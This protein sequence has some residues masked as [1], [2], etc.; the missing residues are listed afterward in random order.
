MADW[1]ICPRGHR[2]QPTVE[3]TACPTCTAEPA[4]EAATLVHPPPAPAAKT[5]PFVPESPGSAAETPPQVPGYEVLG[6]LGRGG[7]GVVYKARHLG[8]DRVVALKMLL[9]V[10]HASPE[11]INR[12]RLEARSVARLQHPHIVQ[13]YEVGEQQGTAFLSLEYCAGG[14]LEQKLAGTPLPP[15][16]AARLVA[17]LA[18]AVQAAHDA[19]IV[20]RDLKPANVLLTTE[21]IAKITDFGLAKTMVDQGQTQSGMILGTPSYMSP[22]QASGSKRRV[23]GPPTDIYALG[24]I[25]YE[26]LTGRPPFRGPTSLDTLMQVSADEPARPSQLQPLT[27]RDLEIICLKCLQKDAKRRYSQARDLADDLHRYLRGEPIHARPTPAWE[28]S[29]KWARRNPAAALIV[30]LFAVPLPVLLLY[31]AGLWREAADARDEARNRAAREAELRNHAEE[32]R[33]R[34]EELA[35]CEGKARDEIAEDHK[36]T[37]AMLYAARVSLAQQEWFA[38]NVGRT[39]QLLDEC[40]PGLRGWEWRHLRSLCSEQRLLID[41]SGTILTQ[42]AWGG[43]GRFL[44]ARGGD[45]RLHIWDATTGSPG[46]VLPAQVSAFAF[47]PDGGRLVTAEGKEVHVWAPAT[48]KE[49]LRFR[50]KGSFLSALAFVEE[51]QTLGVAG[52][53]GNVEFFDAL[54][55]RPTRKFPLRIGEHSAV[56]F[57]PDGR[58]IAVAADDEVRVLDVATGSVKR[59][60]KG[61]LL[62]I[63]QVAFS[64][65]GHRVAASG[66]DGYVRVWDVEDGRELQRL[67]GHAAAIRTLAWSPDGRLLLTGAAD[68][69]ARLWNA[70]S[71][72]MLLTFRGHHGEVLGVAFS[73]EGKQAATASRDG[74]LRVWDVEGRRVIGTLVRV[75][76]LANRDLQSHIDVVRQ[77]ATT[78]WGHLGANRS[79]AFHPDGKRLA[80]AADGDGLVKVW[81]LTNRLEL[82]TVSVPRMS[83]HQLLFAPVGETLAVVSTQ[84]ADNQPAQLTLEDLREQ[85]TKTL[86]GPPCSRTAGAFR[87]DGKRFA[88]LVGGNEDSRIQVL[89]VEKGAGVVAESSITGGRLSGL[90]YTPDGRFL[91]VVGLDGIMR[92]LNAETC[93][94]EKVLFMS[95]AGVVTCTANGLLALGGAGIIR[96]WDLK[97][98]RE[99]GQ[100]SGHIGVVRSLA[101]NPAG[102]RLASCGSDLTA[103]VWHVPDRRELLTF[104]SH[105]GP[106]HCVAWSPDGRRLA[107]A[108][109]DG[110]TLLFEAPEVPQTQGWRTLFRDDFRRDALGDS[111][112]PQTGRWT[113][114]DGE[115][116]GTLENW[117]ANRSPASADLKLD[118][119]PTVAVSF[120][121]QSS[122]DL[123]VV[124]LDAAQQNALKAHLRAGTG[125]L[126]S[127][128]LWRDS[129]KE[130]SALLD[131]DTQF[132][133][134]PGNR[135]RLQVV[136]QPQRLTLIVDDREVLTTKVPPL[137]TPRLR[138]QAVNA[139]AGSVLHLTNFQVTAPPEAIREQALTR[140]VKRV[141]A[142]PMPRGL[143]A[144]FVRSLRNLSEEDM[145]TA[146]RLA[147]ELPEDGPR[148]HAAA[149]PVLLRRDFVPGPLKLQFRQAQAAYELDP[150][151]PTVAE[152]QA[153]ALYRSEKADKALAVLDRAALQSQ[154]AIGLVPPVQVAVRALCQHAL[155]QPEAARASLLQLRDLMLNRR[156]AANPEAASLLAEA[157][158]AVGPTLPPPTATER[159]AQAVKEVVLR[160]EQAGWVEHDRARWLDLF[161]ED[162]EVST[163][164]SEKPGPEDVTLDRRRLDGTT[165]F[166]FAGPPAPGSGF[167]YH[168]PQVE[169]DGDVARVRLKATAAW[170]ESFETYAV[171]YRLRRTAKGWKVSHLRSWS[172]VRKEGPEFTH[173]DAET[174][175]KLDGAVKAA[176]K[177]DAGQRIDALFRARRFAEAHAAAREQTDKPGATAADW[178]RRSRLALTAGDPD[179][180]LAALRRAHQ[181]DPTAVPTDLRSVLSEK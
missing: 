69:T 9:H 11:A 107:S 54:Q 61:P 88:W 87:P 168:D 161:T 23:V 150:H 120:E 122:A 139:A 93:R 30:F 75:L 24:A 136:R 52:W 36:R 71:G 175:A 169:I 154:A 21:G 163:G 166:W 147:A 180:A 27:P 25:L 55:A 7:M 179:D 13:V 94:Q 76:A 79:V 121:C 177:D 103:K 170:E 96:L 83:S 126:R 95:G 97:A 40:P 110:T 65:D 86:R 17:D 58:R 49:L 22:E 42:V 135:Y 70:S 162:V 15:G 91:V 149:R 116:Q 47:S 64:P 73:P 128:F 32:L 127:A 92:I 172:L 12:F 37:E 105:G 155:G 173:Y 178:V 143:A 167:T 10:E 6:V 68:L 134:D 34:A 138:I 66:H 158:A 35:K 111:W 26:C 81:D 146:L 39:R 14:N 80:T 133:I 174:F 59:R 77:E 43:D 171:A 125:G 63:S 156:L 176:R 142:D 2:W 101:F 41:D 118:L 99:V 119:P 1:Q 152:T 18:G 33:G 72:D 4:A 164:R 19:G 98:G 3:V 53:D 46:V 102:D 100:L 144:N 5:I 60:W 113:V 28:R 115:L 62:Y 131:L 114:S 85:K 8:L 89:D 112:L 90:T 132:A 45:Q 16:D 140:Q 31:V 123:Q 74:A 38:G 160:G 130:Q 50:T 84:Q 181:I 141:L 137:A 165:R 78:I 48:G 145:Q 124:L 51:G 151:D 109:Q 129:G 57:S 104:R 20:H 117:D 56:G 157:E 82:Q 106:V 29:W 159:E 153:L 108:G 67:R 148:L 44:A